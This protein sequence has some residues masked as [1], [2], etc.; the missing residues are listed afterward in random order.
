MKHCPN[1][2]PIIGLLALTTAGIGA[3]NAAL[4]SS[5]SFNLGDGGYTVGDITGQN[6]AHDFYS[7]AWFKQDPGH[8]VNIVGNSLVWPGLLSTGGS[9]ATGPVGRAGRNLATAWDATTVGTHC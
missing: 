6:P 5:E 9:L 7:G 3:A 2:G 4:L 8:T 1:P